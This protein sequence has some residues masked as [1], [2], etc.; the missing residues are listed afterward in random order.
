V[1][2]DVVI[3]QDADLEYRPFDYPALLDPIEQ[4]LA[5]VVRK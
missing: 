2:G 3:I 1:T 5:D 4:D